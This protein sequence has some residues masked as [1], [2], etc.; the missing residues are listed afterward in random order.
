MNIKRLVSQDAEEEWSLI[1]S[2]LLL[3]QHWQH[4]P[5]IVR[6]QAADVFGRIVTS[7]PKEVVDAAEAT[8]KQ[9]QDRT[10]RALARQGEAQPGVQSV[11]DVEIRKAAL[12]TLFRALEGQGHAF[13]CG[14]MSIFSILRSACP[15]KASH[16]DPAEKEGNVSTQVK[17]AS[18][19]KV[20]FPSLQLVCSDFLS[21]L[22][23][24]EL[25]MCIAVL[26]EY[27]QQTEDVNVALTVC[28]T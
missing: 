11:T 5:E 7:A 23:L 27:G 20:A 28:L 19:V 4:A 25:Q 12:D 8:Q 13:V 3:V 2:H 14:W 18:L 24:E 1:T 26:A 21:A 15:P 16:S 10:L 9:V 6:L 17:T 22:S